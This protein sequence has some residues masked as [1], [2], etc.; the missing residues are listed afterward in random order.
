M[1][2]RAWEGVLMPIIIAIPS[3]G[4]AYVDFSIYPPPRDFLLSTG[5]HEP[6]RLWGWRTSLFLRCT[7]NPDGAT[8]DLTTGGPPRLGVALRRDGDPRDRPSLIHPTT[9]THAVRLL[10]PV[11]RMIVHRLAV[12]K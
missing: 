5:V 10:T 11:T 8:L 3:C 12:R 6:V 7:W 1:A 9:D 2:R 4:H